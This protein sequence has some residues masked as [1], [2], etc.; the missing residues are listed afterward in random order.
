MEVITQAEAQAD[1]ILGIRP[2]R[3]QR[4]AR[5]GSIQTGFALRGLKRTS[6]FGADAD[7]SPETSACVAWVPLRGELVS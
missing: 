5:A 7:A 3:G 2:Q 6:T 4:D 1:D